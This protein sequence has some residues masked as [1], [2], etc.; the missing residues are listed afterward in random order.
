[1][2]AKTLN[3]NTIKTNKVFLKITNDEKNNKIRVEPA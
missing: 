1:M 2:W 3:A